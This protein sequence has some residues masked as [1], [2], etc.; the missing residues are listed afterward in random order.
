MLVEPMTQFLAIGIVLA[1]LGTIGTVAVIIQRRR[2]WK[3]ICQL[4]DD[5]ERC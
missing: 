2:Q 3:E 1:V 4:A 5:S